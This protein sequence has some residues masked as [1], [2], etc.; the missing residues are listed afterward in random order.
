M[1]MGSLWEPDPRPH[2]A[3]L[4]DWRG[5]VRR[6]LAALFIAV[7]ILILAG[8]AYF[9]IRVFTANDA[10]DPN[11]PQVVPYMGDGMGVGNGVRESER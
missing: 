3:V 1:S 5:L 2:G 6:M 4:G 9:L 10:G 11:A 7:A 8:M